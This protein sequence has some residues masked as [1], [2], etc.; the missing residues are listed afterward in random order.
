MNDGPI[1]DLRLELDSPRAI[2]QVI[3][4]EV[5]AINLQT[6]T[7]YSLRGSAAAIWGLLL[8]GHSVAGV[9]DRLGPLFAAEPEAIRIET[10]RFVAELV[11]ESLV[12]PVAGPGGGAIEAGVDGFDGDPVPDEADGPG[13][14]DFDPPCLE[15]F[16]DMEDLLM[17]DPVHD[18]SGEGWPHVDAPAD[19]D[20]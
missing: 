15:R 7:Y 20:G 11:A 3:D 14:I 12:R 5:V 17:F 9:A 4:D 8:Q 16:T 19:R 2:A 13:R 6:G 1:D 18:V 10:E